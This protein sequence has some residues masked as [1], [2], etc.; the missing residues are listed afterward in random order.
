V[1]TASTRD[2]GCSLL[3]RL[4]LIGL[5]VRQP[6]MTGQLWLGSAL[7]VHWSVIPEA[8]KASEISRW[9]AN[10]KGTDTPE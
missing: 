3:P 1:R 8:R 7:Y 9:L 5:C 4:K 10:N 2:I 6:E